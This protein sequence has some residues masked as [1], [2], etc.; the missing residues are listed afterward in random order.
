MTNTQAT[1]SG[2]GMKESRELTSVLLALLFGAIL[3]APSLKSIIEPPFSWI[4]ALMLFYGL[5]I[6]AIV[7]LAIAFYLT[8]SAGKRHANKPQSIGAQIG[9]IAYIFLLAFIGR[10]LFDDAKTIPEI[11]DITVSNYNPIPGNVIKFKALTKAT[12]FTNTSVDWTV[13]GQTYTGTDFVH[14]AVP[15][16]VKEVI[17]S[18][19]IV[20]TDIN[21]ITD[22][23][24]Q[25]RRLILPVK[26]KIKIKGGG[27]NA[28][29]QAKESSSC[30]QN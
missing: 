24:K 18:V 29:Y 11:K 16:N 27:P 6:F 2:D 1:N 19:K 9:F 12:D 5:A 17:V 21:K 26:T 25:Q 10:N 23:N 28:Q 14:Y 13:N 20:D 15:M 4:P 7:M 3:F 22:E 8:F 30:S